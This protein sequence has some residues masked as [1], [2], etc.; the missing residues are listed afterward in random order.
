MSFSLHFYADLGNLPFRGLRKVTNASYRLCPKVKKV[1]QLEMFETNATFSTILCM[2]T[3]YFLL[4][5][6]FHRSS[7]QKRFSTLSN[8]PIKSSFQLHHRKLR[9]EATDTPRK[10]S[11]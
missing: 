5:G 9:S 8:I 11:N 3:M 6:P 10:W 7:R 1:I 2:F 4:Y